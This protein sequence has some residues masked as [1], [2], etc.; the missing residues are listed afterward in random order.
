MRFLLLFSLFAGDML[1]VNE[2]VCLAGDEGGA[3]VD[4]NGTSF[5]CLLG[6]EL[7]SKFIDLLLTNS[8]KK[9]D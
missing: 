9:F 1:F 6:S 4:V 2:G 7:C 5:E 8:F 3:S